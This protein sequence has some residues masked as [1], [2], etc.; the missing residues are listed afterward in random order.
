VRRDLAAIAAAATLLLAA[1][2]AFPQAGATLSDPPVSC[3]AFARTVGG[4]WTVTAPAMLEFDGMLV[5]FTVGTHLAPGSS[6]HGIAVPV[7]LDRE[8]GN[9]PMRLLR[10]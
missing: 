5:S 3:S 7:I 2:P 1:G 4:G 8:C 6:P 10:P 9:R